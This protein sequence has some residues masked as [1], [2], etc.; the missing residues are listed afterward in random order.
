MIV[1]GLKLAISKDG[2]MLGD[3]VLKWKRRRTAPANISYAVLPDYHRDLLSPKARRRWII[4]FFA[5]NF[6]FGFLFALMPDS[7]KPMMASPILFLAALIVWMLPETGNPPARMMTRM[8]F[9]Y[10]IALILWPYYLAIQIPGAPLIEIRRAFL[11]LSVFFFLVSLSVS[12][13]FIQEMKAI[14]SPY[15]LFMKFFYG[16]ILAQLLSMIGTREPTGSAL[17]MIKNQMAWT[18]VF[19]ISAY[20][21]SK[22]GQIL[23]FSNLIRIVATILAILALFEYRNQGILWAKHIPSFLTVSDPAMIRLL[24]PVFREGDYRVTGTFSVSLCFAEFMSLT[25]PFF[26][27]Y[28]VV[29]RN[30]LYKLI[31]VVCDVLVINAIILTQARVGIVGIMVTHGIYG[32]IWSIRFWRTRKDSLFGPMIALS[33]PAALTVFAMAMLFIGRLREMWMGGQSTYG[34]TEGRLAQAAKFPSVFIHRP[35]FGYGPA[36]GGRALDFRNQAGEMSIDSSLLSIPLNYGAFG[37]ICYVGIFAYMLVQGMRLAFDA[38]EEEASYAMPFAVTI[39]AWLTS[40]I[41]LAQEDNAS[42]MFMVLG[43][44]TALAYQRKVRNEQMAHMLGRTVPAP[45]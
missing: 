13:R 9:A 25:L 17:S 8:F 26:L 22:P 38:R 28:L 10:F 37:F 39:A 19:F 3:M 24:S 15:P 43:A 2:M 11:F 32:F 40:R 16:F 27:Q 29:G 35:L 34:S 36:Q 12:H 45:I 20:I 42:F 7:A 30:R 4:A 44:L 14:I 41:V 21:L 1:I 33:Y 6:V 5:A 18:C 23:R 31:V